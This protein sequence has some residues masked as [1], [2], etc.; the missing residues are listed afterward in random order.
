MSKALEN[1]DRRAFLSGLMLTAG[2]LLVP[3]PLMVAVPAE[4]T[5]FMGELAQ[6]FIGLHTSDPCE[7]GKQTNEV[8]YAGYSR[9]VHSEYKEWI[10]DVVA[11]RI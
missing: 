7:N 3:K 6:F 11:G 10:L 1:L 8:S 5:A 4:C 9:G 2:G